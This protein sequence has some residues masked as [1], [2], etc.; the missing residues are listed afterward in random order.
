MKMLQKGQMSEL[1]AVRQ[2]FEA[3]K[4][5]DELEHR[6]YIRSVENAKANNRI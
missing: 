3:A 1:L 6:L 2:E 5:A 4:L